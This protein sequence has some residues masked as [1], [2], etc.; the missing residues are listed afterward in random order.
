MSSGQRNL[1]FSDFYPFYILLLS[2]DLGK[3][4][5]RGKKEE[6]LRDVRI[7]KNVLSKN[8]VAQKVV[9]IM[10]KWDYIQLKGFYT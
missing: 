4:D 8:P 10:N 6:L 5:A 9:P 3:E 1:S 7:C 2:S